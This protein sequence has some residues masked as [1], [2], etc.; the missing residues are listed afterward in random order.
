MG[1][2]PWGGACM[3]MGA[4]RKGDPCWPPWVLYMPTAMP[5]CCCLCGGGA[6]CRSGGAG[7][8]GEVYCNCWGGRHTGRGPG[9]LTRGT[10][11]MLPSL[12]RLLLGVDML[13]RPVL[14]VG[15][16]LRLV[17]GFP[18]PRPV[19]GMAAPPWPV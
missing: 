8:G 12:P 11:T 2:W 6:G 19:L 10:G 7:C 9:C 14:P 3:N 15:M 17:L 16:L 18:L 13:P 1:C 5:V 4:C